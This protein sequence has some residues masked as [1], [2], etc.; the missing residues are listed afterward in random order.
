MNG[1]AR[2]DS[3]NS[4]N[5]LEST[6]GRYDP[7]EATDHAAIVTVSRTPGDLN[8]GNADIY[9]SVATG[10][11]GTVRVGPNGNVGSKT[12]NNDPAHNGA[13][14]PGHYQDNANMQIPDGELPDPFGP[15]LSPQQ[16]VVDNVSYTYVLGNADYR[17][18][19]IELR[20]KQNILVRGKARIYVQG[21]TSVSGQAR[22]IIAP[23]GSLE[24]YAGRAVDL[25]GGGVMNN[26]YAK[27]FSIVGL[28]T[29][30]SVKYAGNSEF[31]GDNLRPPRR[32]H[33]DWHV[34]G[35]W[36]VRGQDLHDRRHHGPALRRSAARGSEP[37]QIPCGFVGGDEIR[38]LV[39]RAV[40][41]GRESAIA[42]REGECSPSGNLKTLELNHV[43]IRVSDV[44]RSCTFYREV[45]RLEQIPR[46]GFDFPGAWFRLGA[47]QELHIIGGEKVERLIPQSRG[48][49]FALRVD[50]LQAWQQYLQPLDV[51]FRGPVK[52]PDGAL[53]L[54]IADPDG[55]AIELFTGP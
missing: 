16:G 39:G 50:D 3:F 40:I 46:P 25:A 6:N 4:T 14:E 33:H 28:N 9:G 35:V 37:R 32:R 11:G 15:T 47:V 42:N 8:L 34:R 5:D 41:C 52:R 51:I 21:A 22:I 44:E 2:V 10:P 26:G 18:D 43:A 23:G 27:N 29:C 49:H 31:T 1:S 53:Q 55:H 19:M 24:L 38:S 36:G 12:Y 20:A 7:R 54:F 48:N 13:V 17:I 30:T 45:L